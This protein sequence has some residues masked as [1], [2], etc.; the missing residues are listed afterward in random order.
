MDAVRRMGTETAL[1]V[2]D[3]FRI[4]V[5]LDNIHGGGNSLGRGSDE[6]QES[7][8]VGRHIF[9]FQLSRGKIALGNFADG[10]R[11]AT[12][13]LVNSLFY[14]LNT[15]FQGLSPNQVNP[16]DKAYSRL[17]QGFRQTAE[18]QMS[19]RIDQPRQDS[20]IA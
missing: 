18:F 5:F 2:G 6:F 3:I 9:F 11:A 17:A 19:M 8:A 4:E 7:R 15:D 13:T 14:C 16:I 12:D 1:P 20:H 10:G